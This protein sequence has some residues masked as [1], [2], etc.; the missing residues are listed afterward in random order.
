MEVEVTALEDGELPVRYTVDGRAFSPPVRWRDLLT[1]VASLALAMETVNH[2][3]EREA[4]HWLAW[5]IDPTSHGLDEGLMSKPEPDAPAG[6]VQGTASSGKTGYDA[7]VGTLNRPER[8]A[9]HLFALDGPPD[10]DPAAD[11]DAFDA[12]IAPHTIARAETRFTYTR[13]P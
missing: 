2:E 3:G 10:L 13:P 7:P 1:G 5:G 12:A 8:L 4:V 11:A 9:L 6:L